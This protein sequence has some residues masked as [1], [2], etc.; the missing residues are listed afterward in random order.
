MRFKAMGLA[1]LLAVTGCADPPEIWDRAQT[2]RDQF[3]ADAAICKLE[4][5][6]TGQP[7]PQMNGYAAEPATYQGTSTV[8]VGP[9]PSARFGG[10]ARQANFDARDHRQAVRHCM[11]SKGYILRK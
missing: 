4:A 10:N 8:A 5:S 1:G 6:Q 3:Q 7:Q 2:T 9:D 11:E